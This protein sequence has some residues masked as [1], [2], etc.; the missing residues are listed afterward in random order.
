MR[1]HARTA[2]TMAALPPASPVQLEQTPELTARF[3]RKL[4]G[5]LKNF[6]HY[7]G[8]DQPA[9]LNALL[10]AAATCHDDLSSPEGRRDF[11]RTHGKIL[12]LSPGLTGLAR[13]LREH[14]AAE[15]LQLRTAYPGLPGQRDPGPDLLPIG[16]EAVCCGLQALCAAGNLRTDERIALIAAA[17]SRLAHHLNKLYCS[18][19]QLIDDA[20]L[21]AESLPL[22]A[23]AESAL[24][25][26]ASGPAPHLPPAPGSTPGCL[27]RMLGHL[28]A[29]ADLPAFAR[30]I[31]ANL[32]APLLRLV[33]ND[34]GTLADEESPA[35]R[36]LE[37]VA[38]FSAGFIDSEPPPSSL[39]RLNIVL[40]PLQRLPAPG[41]DHFDAARDQ[42]AILAEQT[43]TDALSEAALATAE[44]LDHRAHAIAAASGA[45]E[46]LLDGHTPHAVHTFLA[47]WWAP[48]LA[49]VFQTHGNGHPQW[50][51]MLDV[52]GQ[53]VAS[54]RR[55]ASDGERLQLA[56]SLPG[57]IR[58]I[59]EGLAATGLDA[60]ARNR[61]LQPCMEMH[62]ARLC[63]KKL[64]AT[65]APAAPQPVAA[66][67][68]PLLPCL[69]SPSSRQLRRDTRQNPLW[70]KPGDVMD[71]RLPDSAPVRARAAWI[72]PHARVALFIDASGRRVFAAELAALEALLHS[73]GARH[74]NG[75]TIV[76]TAVRQSSN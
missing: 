25:S 63:G 10:K 31:I 72:G 39:V 11:A 55:P 5:T 50:Q 19:N 29:H 67:D 48:V 27:E 70:L 21:A 6:A 15:L 52:A 7:S 74:L 9:E 8:H 35:R 61:A 43:T 32:R 66:T 62:T 69:H 60:A 34:P 54:G 18:F 23:S 53:L 17:A 49:H 59:H 28:A 45:L 76:T 68:A 3:R 46:R 65:A 1:R 22:P 38:G 42:V 14:C 30:A 13:R 37:A 36:L 44:Q 73:G 2:S 57:L 33:Q 16:P 51:E 64:P 40:K 26:G 58:A 41:P 71:I 47:E 4:L 12:E 24:D 56:A 20:R 75:R